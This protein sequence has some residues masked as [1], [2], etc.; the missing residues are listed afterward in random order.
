MSVE[1]DL[2][3]TYASNGTP[4]AAAFE[5]ETPTLPAHLIRLPGEWAA[6]RCI[7]LRGA[8]FPASYVLRLS[9]PECA[10]AADEL[11]SAG[12][13]QAR[14]RRAALD[15]LREELDALRLAAPEDEAARRSHLNKVLRGV[16]KDRVPE[17]AALPG[18]VSGRTLAALEGL[19]AAG[20]LVGPARKTFDE[21]FA[22]TASLS[23]EV[24]A[25]ASSDRFREAVLWQN[26]QA[27]HGSVEALLRAGP[28]E[29]GRTSHHRRRVGLVA[30]YLQR[31]CLKNDTIGFFGPVGWARFVDDEAALV[32]RPGPGLV[33]AR[34]VYFEGW[35][36]DVLADKLAEDRALL[37]WAVPR[38]M[39]VF[40]VEGTTLY[41]PMQPPRT[42]PARQAALLQA[43]DGE[44]TAREV[45]ETLLRTPALGF[46]SHEQ[47]YQLLEIFKGRGVIAWTFEVPLAVNPDRRLRRILE[48]VE[49]EDLRR[50][51]L[52]VLDELE[53][54]RAEVAA[55]RDVAA[56]DS[57]FGR[58][59]KTFTKLTG[60]PPIRPGV[61]GQAYAARTLVYEDATRDI[62]VAVGAQ[63]TGALAE[64]L[65][66]L[67][68]SARWLTC[69]VAG[70][71]RRTF[72]Q[73]YD[74][75]ARRSGS[76]VVEMSQFWYGIVPTIFHSKGSPLDALLTA[77]QRRWAEVLAL[78]E[79]DARRIH[80]R[81]EELRPKVLA[82]FD[83]PAPGWNA[84]RYHSPDVLLAAAD[85]EAVRR[86]DYLLVLGELHVG[87]NTLRASFFGAQHPS[88]QEFKGYCDSDFP[89]PR[90]LMISPKFWPGMTVRTIPTLINPQ[91]WLLMG[92]NDTFGAPKAQA[93]NIGALVMERTSEGLTV[94]TRDGSLRFDAVEAF[95]DAISTQAVNSFKLLEPR[96]HTPRVS[97]DRLVVCRETWRFSTAEAG[98]AFEASEAERFVETRRWAGARGIPRF[99]F[100][101]S[102]A[103]PKPCYVDFTSPLYVE[104]FIRAIRRA[105]EAQPEGATITVSE[106]LPDPGQNWLHD[107]EG[108]RYTSEL[109]I[110]ALDLAGRGVGRGADAV[111]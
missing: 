48:R 89:E 46:E 84:A 45:A 96:S 91:D 110:V 71:F 72:D 22:A 20:V 12:E 70:I 68:D 40:H 37:P 66:L 13:A 49:D 90:V 21:A 92:T 15:A 44:R 76:P 4:R 59:E 69:E 100:Y 17:S 108:N 87:W 95:G 9:A 6:W 99:A 75:L 58:L 77:F 23:A 88:P 74:G 41:V 94:R 104:N 85:A 14:A 65:S 1:Q 79:T 54:A 61:E 53:A 33:T 111:S 81:C 31:Y 98:F 26:R 39:P 43:C 27:L 103:E 11:L 105:A 47:V 38:L 102:P 3:N 32:T 101:K 5:P 18:W 16:K 83:A 97:F 28:E 82:A 73:I 2:T 50:P 62:D 56:L 42:I 67:L 109:R 107:A 57:S 24:V 106:M 52:A 35:A 7:A 30:N 29:E 80:Y 60:A 78:P 93:L 19:R 25:L 63:L 51:A 55:A 64:P 34:T 10:A 86:G 36:I 8:G